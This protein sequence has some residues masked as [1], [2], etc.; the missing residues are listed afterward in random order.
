MI[1]KEKLIREIETLRESIRTDWLHLATKPLQQ[2]DRKEIRRHIDS[3][4]ADLKNVLEQLAD[5]N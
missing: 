2:N 5:S 1:Q 4:I 3:C